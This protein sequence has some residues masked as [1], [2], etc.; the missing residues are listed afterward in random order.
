MVLCLSLLGLSCAIHLTDHHWDDI[1]RAI[2]R[3]A[4]EVNLH[5][6]NVMDAPTYVEA[7]AEVARHAPVMY[8]RLAEVRD[9]LDDS[10]CLDGAGS[11]HGMV[12]AAAARLDAYVAETD[13][14][15]SRAD[16]RDACERY[17]DDMDHLLGRMLDRWDAIWCP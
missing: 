7:R 8:A 12:D 3:A 17:G 10:G 16:L 13:T 1:D 5:Y 9:R 11:M 2:Q 14:M 4:G 15:A 6:V